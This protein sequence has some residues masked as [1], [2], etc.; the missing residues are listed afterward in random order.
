MEEWFVFDLTT[1]SIDE[2]ADLLEKF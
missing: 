1:I 2:M